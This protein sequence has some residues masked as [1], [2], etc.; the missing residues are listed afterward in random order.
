MLQMAYYLTR[1][2]HAHS[3]LV[4]DDLPLK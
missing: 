4:L 2:N 1:K 3:P